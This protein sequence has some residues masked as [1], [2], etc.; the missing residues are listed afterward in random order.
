MNEKTICFSG[1]RPE[2]LPESPQLV[3]DIKSLLYFSIYESINQGYTRFLTGLARGIDLWA[4]VYVAEFKEKNP[5]IQLIAVS[6]FRKHIDGFKGEERED[7]QTI[8]RCADE[9]IFTSENYSRN[10]Y[11]IRNRYMVEHS[12]KLIAFV[13][14]YRSGTGQTIR[15]AKEAGI[16]I[17]TVNLK[18]FKEKYDEA[19]EKKE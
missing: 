5:D 9:I 14:N 6:P 13:S 7:L 17:K 11:E 2:K 3:N 12:D 4:G 15:I 1:H 8:L 10:V 18:E 19:L 16:E